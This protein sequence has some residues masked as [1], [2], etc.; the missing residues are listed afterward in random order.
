MHATDLGRE[1]L[2]TATHGSAFFA[3]LTLFLLLQLALAAGLIGLWLLAAVI[4]ALIR[5]LML[6]LDARAR[7]RDSKPPGIELFSWFESAWSLV[8]IIH[9]LFLVYTTYQLDKVFPAGVAY[10]FLLLAAV[11]LPASLIVLAVTRTPTEC[12]RPGAIAALI[13]R[14]GPGM[15]RSPP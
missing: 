7:D 14:C 1:F 10:G 6:L 11:L 13:R 12:I 2:Y 8:P 3:F 4:P 5:Y 15:S 9:L